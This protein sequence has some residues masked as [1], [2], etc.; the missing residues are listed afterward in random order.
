MEGGLGVKD[1][2]RFK[3]ALLGKWRWRLLKE[4]DALWN[5]V[6]EAKY[7]I[8][9]KRIYGG[10]NVKKNC[11]EWWKELWKLDREV[12][13]RV[14]W[15]QQ[16]FNKDIGEENETLFWQ[17][18]WC[19]DVA[20][21][22]KF[23]RLY[24]LAEDK[25]VLVKDKGEWREGEWFWKWRWRRELLGREYS[26][27]QELNGI[28]ESK[29]LIQGQKDQWKW[30]HDTKGNY[31]TIS[32]YRALSSSTR[33]LDSKKYKMLWN[34]NVPLKV[35]A[36][37]W[38]IL[39]NRIPT[40][41]NLIKR[42]ITRTRNDFACVFCSHKPESATQ[43]FFTCDTSWKVWQACYAWWG[44]QSALKNEGWGHLQQHRGMVSN[45]MLNKSWYV[46]WFTVLW[47]IWLWRNQLMFKEGPVSFETTINQIK[48]R[49]FTW[50]KAKCN[51]ELSKELWFNNPVEASKN[52]GNR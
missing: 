43:L 10:G 34:N 41:D 19:G 40:G 2:N 48:L 36:L 52:R 15:I 35:S 14:G 26:I 50:L 3:L 6:V 21:K 7:S 29:K 38:K 31:S 30:R 13:S 5:R 1:L 18:K 44:I 24:R 47:S 9:R 25:E 16:G 8:H 27:L 37:A 4:K 39:Q 49:S 32:A 51:E 11:S 22:E 42:G 46:I 33:E 20:F 45:T 12:V 28:L 17:D 23:N